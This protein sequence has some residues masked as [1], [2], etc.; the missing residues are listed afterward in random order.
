MRMKHKL[1][2]RSQGADDTQCH[3]NSFYIRSPKPAGGVAMY[4]GAD[5]SLCYVCTCIMETLHFCILIIIEDQTDA[6]HL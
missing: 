3:D 4:Q 6:K 1:C 2:H 5:P